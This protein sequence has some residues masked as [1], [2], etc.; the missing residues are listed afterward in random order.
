MS[1][2]KDTSTQ[3]MPTIYN[4]QTKDYKSAFQDKCDIFRS[5]LFPPPPIITPINLNNYQA[6]KGWK[7]PVLA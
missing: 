5:T 2:T 1:Y 7:W 4:S 6:S 3:P